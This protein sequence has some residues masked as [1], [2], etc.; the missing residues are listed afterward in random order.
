MLRRVLLKPE[1]KEAVE[2]EQRKRVF[3]TKCKIRDKCFHL[4]IDGGN[5]K[6][7]V[8]TKVMGKLKLKGIPNPNLY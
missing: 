4:V 3:N 8:S 6:E 1:T 7:L 2:A 5:K